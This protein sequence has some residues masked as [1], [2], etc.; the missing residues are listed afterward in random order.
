MPGFWEPCPGKRN[1]VGGTTDPESPSV[2]TSLW[3]GSGS[4]G[5]G[6]FGGTIGRVASRLRIEKL[7]FGG[8]GLARHTDGTVFVPYVLP[9][10]EVVAEPAGRRRGVTRA[11]ATQWL[12]RS[13]LRRKPRC[14]VFSRCGGCHYQHAPYDRELA[15]KS[16][17]LRETLRRTG[18][19]SWQGEIPV[20]ASRAW[21]Y[22][23]R[24]RV[25]FHH[26]GRS[27]TVGFLAPASHSHVATG[28]CAINSPKLNELHAV[29]EEMAS[30]GQVPTNVDSVE[31]FTDERQV[32]L[33]L[34]GRGRRL[35]GRAWKTC[36]RG[37]GV[38][39][40]GAAVDYRCGS[41]RFRVSPRSFFQANRHLVRRLASLATRSA[42]GR[43][44][45]D[46]Y[47]GVGL[48]TLP[49]ARRFGRV[50]GVD[51]SRPAVRDLR[52]NAE[53]SGLPIL[54]VRSG[55]ARFLRG[56]QDRPDLVVADP[57]RAGLGPAT[58][59]ELLRL[60]APELR[61]VSCDP[62]TLGRDLRLLR[63]GGYSVRALTLVDLFPRTYH[64]ETVTI[65]RR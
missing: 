46:L 59:R 25:R 58:V 13:P 33:N 37:L 28:D 12:V 38:R 61:L 39:R 48:L 4:E 22:R 63:E 65:L 19:W 7:V 43:L 30:S 21:G 64:I 62:A 15:F 32:Q 31:L 52:F 10:E 60:S 47:C 50:V 3:Q 54:A 35:P 1:A 34:P 24:T 41:D 29:L 27:A 44:A 8:A 5:G 42:E 2:A 20:V 26:R 14:P 57:P 53:R 6:G 51:S 56:L 23:N 11:S 16:E 49:L 36:M 17:I 45:I 55:V 9:G 18:G 40:A